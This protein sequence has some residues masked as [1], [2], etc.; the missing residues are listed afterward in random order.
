MS[1]LG[2]AVAVSAAG[3]A[4]IAA[5]DVWLIRTGRATVTQA[6]RTPAGWV[7]LG[8]LVAH[9]LKVLGRWDAFSAIARRLQP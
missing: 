2:P 8:Y 7:V 4:V 5:G 9:F 6:V 3:L 1:E